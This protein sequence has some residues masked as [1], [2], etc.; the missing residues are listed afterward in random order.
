MAGARIGPATAAMARSFLGDA[1]EI[2]AYRE[3]QEDGLVGACEQVDGKAESQQDAIALAGRALQTRQRAE[4]QASRRGRKRAAP[5][6]VHPLA[7]RAE[8]HDRE[9]AAGER[10]DGAGPAAQ[11]P[12]GQGAEGRGGEQHAGPR[13]AEEGPADGHDQALAERIDGA[14]RGGLQDEE[15]FEELVQG[16]RR[17]GQAQVAE[18]IGHQQVAEFV[19]DIGGGDGMVGQERQPQ[20]HRQSRQDGHRPG[21]PFRQLVEER[22]DLAAPEQRGH[23]E[24]AQQKF[25]PIARAEAHFAQLAYTATR[26]ILR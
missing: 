17:I 21:G 10:P 1:D 25:Q 23:Q 8:L 26:V 12:V 11:H 15:G 9:Q 19:I 24:R 5:I 22:G 3:P 2:E 20:H 18:R 6:V 16:M 7:E 4:D 13:R 14:V